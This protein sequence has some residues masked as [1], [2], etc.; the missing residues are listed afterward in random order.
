[1]AGFGSTLANY[2]SIPQTLSWMPLCSGKRYFGK[3]TLLKSAGYNEVFPA[4]RWAHVCI[5]MED[6]TE[7]VSEPH[8]AARKRIT[9]WPILS[10]YKTVI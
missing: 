7:M 1:L 2:Q 9:C 3:I 5:R 10:N 4:E 6:G 8:D